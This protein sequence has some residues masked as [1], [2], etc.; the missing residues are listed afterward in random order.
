DLDDVD[1]RASQA[2]L[3]LRAELVPVGR[4]SKREAKKA[5]RVAKVEADRSAKELFK[6]LGTAGLGQEGKD[7]PA[8]VVDENDGGG[9]AVALGGKKPAQ[10]VQEREITHDQREGSL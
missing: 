6:V 7:S 10:V 8:V 1:A 5:R 4:G 9:E 2:F 3:D